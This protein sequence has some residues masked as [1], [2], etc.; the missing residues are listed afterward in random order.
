MQSQESR[1]LDFSEVRVIDEAYEPWDNL[2][3]LRT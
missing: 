3:V 2:R 1:N